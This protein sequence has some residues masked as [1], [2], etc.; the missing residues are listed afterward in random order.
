M[1]DID[2][3]LE[4]LKKAML[5]VEFIQ[6]EYFVSEITTMPITDLISK[7]KNRLRLEQYK[8]SHS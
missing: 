8:N 2:I 3:S 6:Q 4:D 1:K 7:C 5:C